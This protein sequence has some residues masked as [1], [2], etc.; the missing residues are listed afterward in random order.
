MKTNQKIEPMIIRSGEQL[1]NAVRRL[2]KIYGMSQTGLALKT[3]LAQ[4]TISRIEKG[5]KKTE[6]GT[7]FLI[8]SVLNSDLCVVGRVKSES[9]SSLEGLY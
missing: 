7:V 4:S 9:S 5:S 3:G 2:R 6:I 1:A 8:L